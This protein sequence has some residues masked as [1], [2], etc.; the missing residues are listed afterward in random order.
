MT[1]DRIPDVFPILRGSGLTLRSLIDEDLPAWY[2]R[3]SDSEA[4]TLAGDPVATSMQAV[5]DGLAFH[6]AA[7]REKEGLRWA[8]VP[9]A[10]GI[11]IGTV[12]FGDFSQRHRSAGIGA[13]IGRAQWGRGFVTSAGRLVLEYGFSAL[14]LEQIDAVVLP[15]N[16]RVIRVLEKLGF[17]PGEESNTVDRAIGGRTDTLV[18]HLHRGR[19]GAA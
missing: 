13:A 8:I 1:Y 12:G 2:G 4:T 6:R 9:D 11:S 17:V 14:H 7:F 3:L 18:Y 5:V 16:A 10:L 19:W 15:E